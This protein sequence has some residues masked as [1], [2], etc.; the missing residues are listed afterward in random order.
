MI[1]SRGPPCGPERPR[2]LSPTRVNI[3]LLCEGNPETSDSWSGISQS[4]LSELRALGH[5][6]TWTDVDLYGWERW[7]GAA[8]TLSFDRQ[9][10]WSRYHLTAAPFALR[11]RKARAGETD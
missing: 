11:S 1:T 2:Q 5:T 10:W 8:L 9:R 3:H 4:I 6:V 7:L